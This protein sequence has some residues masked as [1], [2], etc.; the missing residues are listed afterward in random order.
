MKDLDFAGAVLKEGLCPGPGAK[1]ANRV[2]A[3]RGDGRWKGLHQRMHVSGR[4]V[5]CQHGQCM[6]IE[7]EAFC[8]CT[9]LVSVE[10][11]PSVKAIG[12]FQECSSMSSVE[13]AEFGEGGWLA[14]I[15]A[16]AIS[17]C[18]K[19]AGHTEYAGPGCR[20]R[21]GHDGGLSA[22]GSESVGGA[23]RE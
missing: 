11:P 22:R 13:F 14:E 12:G 1:P 23:E 6:A 3:A 7:Q 20:M 9:R 18:G 5:K 10:V 2:E 17:S 19:L 16:S 8:G 21:A 4:A 15:G